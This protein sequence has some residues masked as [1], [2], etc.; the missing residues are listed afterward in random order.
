MHN[1]HIN[2]YYMLDI[3]SFGICGFCVVFLFNIPPIA[4][5]IWRHG[6]GLKSFQQTGK[7]GIEPAT[8]GLQGEWFI[9]YT[10]AEYVVNIYW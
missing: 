10:S 3:G 2:L 8:P 4:K 5:V 1:A 7:P 6:Q 9:H